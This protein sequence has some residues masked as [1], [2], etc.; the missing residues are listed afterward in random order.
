[1][2]HLDKTRLLTAREI[3][4]RL[5]VAP[6]TVARWAREG[7]I[8]CQRLSPRCVRYDLQA[9]LAV[10]AELGSPHREDA[11]PSAEALREHAPS[12]EEGGR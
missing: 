8:P 12:H 2:T 4:F 6:T 11:T 7:A 10:V 3:A 1:M 9:V 5:G